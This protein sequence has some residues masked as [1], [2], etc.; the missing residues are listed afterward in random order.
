MTS[1]AEEVEN[2]E[3]IRRRKESGSGVSISSINN[4]HQRSRSRVV[5]EQELARANDGAMANHT[6]ADL[7]RSWRDSL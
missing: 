3:R 7:K 5:N 4:L 2:E 6:K 1:G